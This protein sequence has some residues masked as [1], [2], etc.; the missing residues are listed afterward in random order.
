MANNMMQ[1]SIEDPVLKINP[2]SIPGKGG[3]VEISFRATTTNLDTLEVEYRILPDSDYVFGEPANPFADVSDSRTS[4]FMDFEVESAAKKTSGYSSGAL[5]IVQQGQG[6]D[7]AALKVVAAVTGQRGTA[8]LKTPRYAI[9]SIAIL[10]GGL[11]KVMQDHFGG[12]LPAG[13][14]AFK[15]KAREFVRIQQEKLKNKYKGFASL[16]PRTIVNAVLGETDSTS[17]TI[18]KLGPVIDH[19]KKGAL[20]QIPAKFKG[21][22]GNE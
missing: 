18:K 21:K 16:D 1:C 6:H 20:D 5:P 17:S 2:G 12:Q 9:G 10:S 13:A 19:F 7:E 3:T 4:V 15:A 14:E 8:K 11:R 22:T